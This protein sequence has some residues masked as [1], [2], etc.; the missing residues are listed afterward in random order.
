[1]S[2]WYI[3]IAVGTLA[4][5]INLSL[6]WAHRDR[7][8]H[9]LVRGAAGLVSLGLAIGVVVTKLILNLH[10][11]TSMEG[12]RSNQFVFIAAGLFI[13]AALML[14][15]Y[16]DRIDRQDGEATGPS[17]QERAARPVNA[18]VRMQ[19]NSDEWVN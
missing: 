13:G 6:G 18:T 9:A 8:V 11:P 1:M 15:S 10:L 17:L 19:K 7:P 3:L 16:I 12:P 5:I 4:A 2:F 14:P